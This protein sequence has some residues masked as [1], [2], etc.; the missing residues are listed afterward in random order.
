M[1]ASVNKKPYR[2]LFIIKTK[3]QREKLFVVLIT[4]LLIN[5]KNSC[6]LLYV[7]EQAGTY[8]ILSGRVE[9]VLHRFRQW[10]ECPRSGRKG[11][12]VALM[13]LGG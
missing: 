1:R 6:F 13:R 2:L 11:C 9:A 7:V 12:T 4:Y 8:D 3:P 5:F 10:I